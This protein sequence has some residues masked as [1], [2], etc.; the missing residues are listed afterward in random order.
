MQNKANFGRVSS[1]KCQVSSKQSQFE[2]SP[3][4]SRGTN[5]PNK[6]NF[7]AGGEQGQGIGKVAPVVTPR[8]KRAKQSQLP[9]RDAKGKYLVEK[10]L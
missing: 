9:P 7:P 5:A 4:G 6:G 8:Q 3:A 2:G 1:P 10:E